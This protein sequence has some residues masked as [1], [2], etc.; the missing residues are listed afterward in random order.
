M[1]AVEASFLELVEAEAHLAWLLVA[2]LSAVSI[3]IGLCILLPS[4]SPRSVAL[5]QLWSISSLAL[6]AIAAMDF[7]V[8][9]RGSLS[10]AGLWLGRGAILSAAI[11]LA[12]VGLPRRLNEFI[13]E[14]AWLRTGVTPAFIGPPA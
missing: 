11:A 13:R 3:V 8:G 10:G 9:L 14:C 7:M 6:C 1:S 4:R 5:V 12:A 2:G